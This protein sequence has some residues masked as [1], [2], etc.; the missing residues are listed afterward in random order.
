MST[1]K[2]LAASTLADLFA[3]ARDDEHLQLCD[4]LVRGEKT[5]AEVDAALAQA[6][7][8]VAD[9]RR[10]S[11]PLDVAQKERLVAMLMQ[12]AT[13]QPALSAVAGGVRGGKVR[14]G[15]SRA[16]IFAA[17]P[18]LAASIAAY[19]AFSAGPQ[20]L[21]DMELD[22]T[23]HDTSVLGTPVSRGPDRLQVH[24]GSCLELRLR[25]AQH[26]RGDLQTMLWLVPEETGAA[27]Q[28]VPWAATL[29]RAE[30][31]TLRLDPCE[32]LPSVVR[33][34]SWQLAV[35]YGR[36]LPPVAAI[37]QALT[38]PSTPSPKW[39]IEKQALQVLAP[40]PA[41]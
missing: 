32:K 4:E 29:H 10:M 24:A 36:K 5:A 22:V 26:Y 12:P 30:T 28:P 13:A 34:G 31:G 35:V 39:Q 38:E 9:I 16:I 11:E 8:R 33:P 41:R 14:S 1:K 21:P 2:P 27:Q 15:R 40:H 17:G 6:S 25:P 18:A 23:A 37:S 20:E 19:V 7:P 3:A